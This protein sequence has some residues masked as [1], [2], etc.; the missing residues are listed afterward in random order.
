MI[1]FCTLYCINFFYMHFLEKLFINNKNLVA[2]YVVSDEQ[3]TETMNIS[4]ENLL[5]VNIKSTDGSSTSGAQIHLNDNFV[6]RRRNQK[7][8]KQ[9]RENENIPEATNVDFGEK[10]AQ[11]EKVLVSQIISR[12]STSF[13]S[14]LTKSD[15]TNSS[16]L[17]G[18]RMGLMSKIKNPPNT[19]L[20]DETY[21]KVRNESP[22]N[23]NKTRLKNDSKEERTPVKCASAKKSEK[24]GTKSPFF[25]PSGLDNSV[26]SK[27]PNCNIISRFEM[28][29]IQ[30]KSPIVARPVLKSLDNSIVS[31]SP[32]C[33]I[34]T[35]LERK[36][37]LAKTP[38]FEKNVTS[39]IV[40]KPPQ[41]MISRTP[42]DVKSRLF[43]SNS[44]KAALVSKSLPRNFQRTSTK[45]LQESKL[46]VFKKPVSV[47]RKTK[48]T[49]CNDTEESSGVYSESSKISNFK[50][51]AMKLEDYL[52]EDF[53]SLSN[54]N[55]VQSTRL[56][57][58]FD[59]G[60]LSSVT[61]AEEKGLNTSLENGTSERSK[62]SI[63]RCKL[64]AKSPE[65]LAHVKS[66][67]DNQVSRFN[68][69]LVDCKPFSKSN[70]SDESSLSTDLKLSDQDKV[71]RLEN[72]L[73]VNRESLMT[74]DLTERSCLNR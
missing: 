14:D 28:K 73:V 9:E 32:N 27:S 16:S 13:S 17:F 61:D 47:N 23:S 66:E 71:K 7:V 62:E 68:D 31:K 20:R 36:R 22:Q 69:S 45:I 3:S 72:V 70:L 39:K 41:K 21:S 2:E 11:D 51:V 19:A 34:V 43:K 24:I 58:S 26:V 59:H 30:E 37:K 65:K 60:I 8:R 63:S 52:P 38:S 5:E 1:Q 67:I 4:P 55:D 44:E 53:Q 50:N 25:K 49:K 10:T 54:N 40:K 74:E 64:K 18:R 56:A 42:C 12:L 48:S 6:T 33:N 15:L 29:S 46:P 35:T 57:E